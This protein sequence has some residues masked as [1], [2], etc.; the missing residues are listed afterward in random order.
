MA[1][2][3]GLT[4][5]KRAIGLTSVLLGVAALISPD[6]LARRAGLFDKDAP[7][8]M[9]AFGAKEIAAGAALLAPV[10]PGPFLWARVAA[11]LVNVG[12]LV[13]A[14]RKPGA[15]RTLLTVLAG[16]AI[17]AIVVDLITAS[18]AVKEGR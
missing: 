3:D 15:H 13:V 12:G 18:Q 9:A 1:A 6:R 14:F 4:L 17:A 11:D 2:I 8:T 16:G 10:R 5:A 7:E